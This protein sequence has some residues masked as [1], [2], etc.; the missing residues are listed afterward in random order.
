V[1]D[2][3]YFAHEVEEIEKMTK[4]F[5]EK[6]CIMESTKSESTSSWSKLSREKDHSEERSHEQLQDRYTKHN[7]PNYRDHFKPQ[8]LNVPEKGHQSHGYKSHHCKD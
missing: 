5:K 4:D 2:I 7:K 8:S 6:K 1:D 3:L